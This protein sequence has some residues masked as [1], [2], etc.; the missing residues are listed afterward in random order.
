MRRVRLQHLVSANRRVLLEST[1]DEVEFDY[2]DIGSVSREKG[3]EG[4]DRLTFG[5]APSRARRI[6]SSGDV[7]VSTVRT[8]LKA[9]A[10][11]GPDHDGN[12]CSTGF[13]VLTP[14]PGISPR[15]LGYL[16]FDQ[17]F[18]GDVA[19]RSVGVSYPAINTS[20]LL[21]IE[22]LA[23]APDDQHVIADFLD[24]ECER[25]GLAMSEAQLAAGQ[26]RAYL[27]ARLDERVGGQGR[28]AVPFGRLATLAARV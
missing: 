7:I 10:S 17:G 5:D 28:D 16:V 23:P 9:A 22:V 20:E 14:R 13:A 18:V 8:Y 4:V 2:I 1:P 19:A 25:I 24:R 21:R 27:Q 12:V 26:L 11:I 15:Y 6:V 3:I